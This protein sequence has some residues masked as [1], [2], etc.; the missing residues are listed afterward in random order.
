LYFIKTTDD[1]KYLDK[2]KQVYKKEK[3]YYK[4]TGYKPLQEFSIRRNDDIIETIRT[5]D[6]L[7]YFQLKTNNL[8][9][10]DSYLWEYFILKGYKPE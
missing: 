1:F 10:S 2:V 4:I 6:T 7:H 5:K 8:L 3:Y 9:D